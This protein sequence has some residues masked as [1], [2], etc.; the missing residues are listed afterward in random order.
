MQKEIFFHLNSHKIF[1]WVFVVAL[2]L[3][4]FF[5]KSYIKDF[6]KEVEPVP[7]APSKYLR[8]AFSMGDDEFLFR[9]L[10]S[11][12]QN[13][14]DIFAGFITLKKYDYKRIYDWMK[15]LDELNYESNFIPS[16]ASYYYSQTPIKNDSNHIINY[17]D[18]HAS[19]NLNKK[20]WWMLQAVYVAKKSLQDN[21]VALKLAKKLSKN[22]SSS[23]PL[24]T[25]QL[26]AFLLKEKGDDCLSFSI[27]S[28]ML[29]KIENEKTKIS[30]GELEYT[31]FYIRQR[32]ISLKKNKFSPKKCLN[33]DY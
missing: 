26:Y 11:R 6:K 30:K 10:G 31:R 29:K 33:L 23:S 27:L 19:K 17:L 4:I 13:S 8:S 16:L 32:L 12:L 18:E 20:W 7:A 2:F 15:S 9:I 28:K 22:T 25:K 14:G 5:W 1:F 3:Q 21:D 24:W